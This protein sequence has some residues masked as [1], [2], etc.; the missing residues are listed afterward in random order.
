MDTEEKVKA[1]EKEMMLTVEELKLLLLDI[2]SFLAEARSPLRA[3][4][5]AKKRDAKKPDSHSIAVKGE[6]Q[7]GSR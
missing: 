1:L 6:E 7:N 5:D 3:K 4:R 2:R